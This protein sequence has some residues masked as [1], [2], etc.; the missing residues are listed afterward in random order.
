MMPMIAGP[1]YAVAP[2]FSK[3]AAM[4]R[5][6]LLNAACSMA[7]SGSAPV[8]LVDQ[9]LHARGDDIA[10][11]SIVLADGGHIVPTLD[12][13]TCR[14]Q[15]REVAAEGHDPRGALEIRPRH[16]VRA[17]ALRVD[18]V[19]AK[20]LHDTR[21]DLRVGLGAGRSRGQGKTALRGE[22]PEVLAR[23][24]AL[25]RA[26]QTHE[27]DERCRAHAHLPRIRGHS[28]ATPDNPIPS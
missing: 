7:L 22:T 28:A 10:G 19:P 4:S 9:S 24:D 26:V 16:P 13:E 11:A 6:W 27:Q 5:Q 17:Q 3:L 2:I 23:D 1:P 15:A 21:R 8:E 12:S 20:S 14:R 18:A 25:R